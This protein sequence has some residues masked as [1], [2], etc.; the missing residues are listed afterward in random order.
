MTSSTLRS[1]LVLALSIPSLLVIGCSDG[2]GG[3]TR[4]PDGGTVQPGLD[5]GPL[6]PECGEGFDECPSGFLCAAVGG[7]PRCV[8]DPD[9]PPPGDGT[10]CRPCD[11][12][13][14]CR[15]GVCVQPSDSGAF[16]EFDPECGEDE[17][18]IAGRCTHDPRIPIPCDASMMCPPPLTCGEDGVCHCAFTTDCPIGL[19]CT[20][21][22]CVPGP[23]G[24]ACFADDMCPPEDLCEAGRCRPR[25]VCDIANP[26]LS[27]TWM[28]TSTLNI[29]E[30]VPA[31]I[32]DVEDIFRF[33]GTDGTC[34]DWSGL[35]D[36]VD[37]E[38]CRLAQ[39]FIAE[40]L[41]P[42]SRDVFRAIADLNVVLDTW[43]IDET[44]TLR[45]GAVADSYRGTHT[46][47]RVTF[48]YRAMPIVG[49]PLMVRDW[50]FS[51]SEFNAS[52][53]CG[54]FNIER[55]TINV[56]IGSIVAW[57]LDAL[58]Y[59]GSGRRWTTLREALTEVA[60]G[61]CD[62][63][64]Q[65]AEEAIDYPNVGTTVDNV[66]TGIV[67]AGVDAAIDAVVNARI[68]ADAITLRGNA[69][70]SGPNTLSPGRWDGTL[71][72]RG[73]SGTFDARR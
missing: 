42:W 27:G 28:M 21:G 9:R 71:V 49:D 29:G 32:A 65:A 57:L 51:P 36:W 52:A 4:D 44:M 19:E 34:I 39:P 31:W 15:M 3:R 60:A 53:V 30:A 5:A 72:G 68:G 11:A 61:F 62:G 35:P 43:V 37:M 45:A 56:S 10:D 55:H 25:T 64:A 69:T 38:I 40:Y 26:D 66:C 46:W 7:I 14:E 70:I 17:L 2:G 73:F 12:P 20:D 23:G 13:G 58:V 48:M 22:L 33:L 67:S 41:P 47:N 1:C 63:L 59:E 50:R 24:G 6:E 18:C 54:E 16:C 8:P